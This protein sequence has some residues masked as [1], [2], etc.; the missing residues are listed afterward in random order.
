MLLLVHIRHG[1]RVKTVSVLGGCSVEGFE[2]RS[3]AERKGSC[4]WRREAVYAEKRSACGLEKPLKANGR[5]VWRSKA[6]IEKKSVYGEEKLCDERA[7]NF[8]RQDPIW[9]QDPLSGAVE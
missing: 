8:Y 5:C 3:P 9:R 7:V 4:D 6:C 2:C 1:E